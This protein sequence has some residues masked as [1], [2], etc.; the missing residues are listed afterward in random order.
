M[1]KKT[2]ALAL[3]VVAIAGFA[4]FSK[5]NSG[6][7][8]EAT[9]V[10]PNTVQEQAEDSKTRSLTMD[11]VLQMAQDARDNAS[12]TLDDYTATFVA[13][14]VEPNG[15]LKPESFIDLKVQTRL[16]ND[17]DDAPK[18][19]YLRFTGPEAVVGREVIWGA[20]LYDGQMAVREVG[21]LMDWKTWWL[22]PNGML[23]MAGQRYPISHI[24]LVSLVEKLI[25]RGAKDLD[26][27][28]VTATLTKGHLI[29]GVEA[30]LI[31]VRRAKPSGEEDDFSM[32]EISIDPKR[33]LILQYRSFGWPAEGQDDVPLQE[34]YTY[35]DIKTNV[36]LTDL[37]FDYTNPEYSFPH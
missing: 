12:T 28:D 19:V 11:E 25:E 1:N 21:A 8:I 17:T 20:D 37:D 36:G 33:K 29:D 26:N 13:Q 14:E 9:N 15:K 35:R 23:A 30:E 32:A 4:L 10:G 24:G 5:M 34:S 27:P 3:F 16:R 2:I 31:Q 18:R 6:G 22:D 7:T